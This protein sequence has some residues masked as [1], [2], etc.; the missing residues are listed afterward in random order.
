MTY[1][2][3]HLGLEHHSDGPRRSNGRGTGRDGE[4]ELDVPLQLCSLVRE[5][6]T[7]RQGRFIYTVL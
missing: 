2:E 4:T 7:E 1:E 6:Q 5:L 3:E